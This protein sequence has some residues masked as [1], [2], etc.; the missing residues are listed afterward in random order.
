VR[1]TTRYNRTQ[2]I[3]VARFYLAKTPPERAQNLSELIGT[4]RERAA[5]AV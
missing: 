5:L 2:A 1:K 3:G 4:A